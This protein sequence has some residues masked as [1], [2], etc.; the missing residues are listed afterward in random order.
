MFSLFLLHLRC[1][2]LDDR[3]AHAKSDGSKYY[4]L[5]LVYVDDV[6]IISH[7]PNVHLKRIQASYDLNQ[8][9]IGPPS[10]YLGADVRR[11]TRPG[12]ASGHEYWSFSAGTY[13]KNAV[14]N[15]KLLLK[16]DG[17]GLKS[18][19]KTPS[20]IHLT[21]LNWILPTSVM[22]KVHRGIHSSLVF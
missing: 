7:N 1:V 13:V 14:R 22:T 2:P 16:E 20:R 18:T 10:R 9:S 4:E 19:A 6:L 3:R 8:S 12:D 11:V 5:I 17:R 21:G 15:V